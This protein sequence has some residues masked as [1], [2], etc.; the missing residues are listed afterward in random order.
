MDPVAFGAQRVVVTVDFSCQ[1]EFV[2]RGRFSPWST[3]I[4]T[5]TLNPKHAPKSQRATFGVLSLI[6]QA[7]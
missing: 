1:D 4:L 3:K 6:T 5:S 7:E 2:Q